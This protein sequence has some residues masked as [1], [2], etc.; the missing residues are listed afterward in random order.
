MNWHSSE[1]VS[2]R[3]HVAQCRNITE[4]PARK[5]V[6]R[7]LEIREYRGTGQRPTQRKTTCILVIYYFEYYKTVATASHATLTEMHF[8]FARDSPQWSSPKRRRYFTASLIN[9][10]TPRT[11]RVSLPG[12]YTLLVGGGAI[13][14]HTGNT[15]T[16]LYSVS[17]PPASL[18]FCTLITSLVL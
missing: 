17:R 11:F 6:L 16:K 3:K 1:M 15:T 5:K 9:T 18:K 10:N 14:L 12:V 7:I 8:A 4:G 13:S 2:G